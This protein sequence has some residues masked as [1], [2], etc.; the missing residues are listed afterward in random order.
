MEEY[1][2]RVISVCDVIRAKRRGKK[3]LNLAFDEYNVWR[4]ADYAANLPKEWHEAPPLLE[5]TY[6]VVDALVLATMMHVL[7]RQAGRVKIGCL[8]QL[9]NVLAPIR[10]LNGGP[11]WKQAIFHPFQIIARHGRGLS[12]QPSLQ[13]NMEK[14]R[15]LGLIPTLDAAAVL[16][17]RS[18][19]IF[20]TNRSASRSVPL[21]IQLPDLQLGSR[22]TGLVLQNR[23]PH[24]T[25]TA[26]RPNAV[27]PQSIRPIPTNKKG[28]K[29][30]L[31]PLSWSWLEIPL[32]GHPR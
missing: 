30:L 22:A 28:F 10:T 3:D 5:D 1:I 11:A 19:S 4:I 26:R 25:N 6:N 24:S 7:L 16:G 31:P 32:A 27:Q 17:E 29:A 9:V 12:L 18:L 8:A 21:E 2:R 20:V 23:N 15:E 14:H 13:C